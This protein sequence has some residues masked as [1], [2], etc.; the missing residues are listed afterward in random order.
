MTPKAIVFDLYGTLYDVH[1][2]ARRCDGHYPGRGMD[3][4]V[5]WRQKQLEY[6]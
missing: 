3:I 6:T 2:V 4:S 5:M 1:S